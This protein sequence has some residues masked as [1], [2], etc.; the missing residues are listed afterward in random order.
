[1]QKVL[2]ELDELQARILNNSES[3]TGFEYLA[4]LLGN[5]DT[6][7]VKTV[8]DNNIYNVV[9]ADHYILTEKG[10]PKNIIAKILAIK[11]L[12]IKSTERAFLV[13]DVIREP[14][15]ACK[16]LMARFGNKEKETFSC[17]YLNSHN[18]VLN[19]EVLFIGTVTQAQIYPM[20]I[21]RGCVK[22]RA[23]SFIMVHNHPSGDCLPSHEDIVL[24][25]KIKDL[26]KQLD[27]RCHDHFVVSS[28][29]VYSIN[30]D[31]LIS[32]F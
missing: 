7:K 19:F 3:L 25:N 24:T 31:R 22:H 6:A 27:L 18:K 8:F 29:G 1:M 12:L 5:K 30:A 32:D 17:I 15:D 26:A 11:H 16:Y 10:L 2:Y 9:N 4:L 23:E 14:E 13:S 28:N 21:I 20:E